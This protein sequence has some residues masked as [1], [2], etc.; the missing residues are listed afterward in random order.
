MKKAVIFDLDGTLLD[1]LES[2]AFCGN[3][4]LTHFGFSAVDKSIYPQFIGNGAPV[5]IEKLYKYIGGDAEKFDEFF[6]YTSDIY[7]KFGSKNITPYDGIDTMLDALKENNIK[8]AVLSN[9]PHTITQQVCKSF[10]DNRFEFVY[11]HRPN[12]P[13]KPDPHMIYE[14]LK[15]LKCD[16]SE[17]IY[18]GDS[19]V[20]VE[21]AK[22]AN[23][24]MLGAAWGFYGDTPFSTADAILY[25]PTDILKYI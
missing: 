10:F 23:I 16:S 12:T 14:I 3:S 4:A 7:S 20:D 18:C 8:C 5:L 6:R 24:T 9:K 19:S 1:T 2:I 21:T 17:C 11:G 22:N 15:E 13:K 25:H